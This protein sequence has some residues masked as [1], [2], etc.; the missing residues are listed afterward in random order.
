MKI[1]VTGGLHITNSFKIHKD[2]NYDNH[3]REL[4]KKYN[5]TNIV[6]LLSITVDSIKNIDKYNNDI[7][8]HLLTDEYS[9]TIFSNIN[10]GEYIIKYQIDNTSYLTYVNVFIL[11]K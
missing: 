5:I 9:E 2:L 6:K 11:K 1:T 8:P 7:Y 10:E 4:K 3:M